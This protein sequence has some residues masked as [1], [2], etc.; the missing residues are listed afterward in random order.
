LGFRLS[1]KMWES[2]KNLKNWILSGKA[3]PFGSRFSNYHVAFKN[4]KELRGFLL[5]LK[6]ELNEYYRH[7][8]F[9][10]GIFLD[11]L[12]LYWNYK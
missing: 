12:T 5:G 11:Y 1:R 7:K 6:G 8:F 9:N 10:Y 4:A 3:I 2:Q